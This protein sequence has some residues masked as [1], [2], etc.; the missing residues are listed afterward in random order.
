MGEVGRQ[1]CVVFD[2]DGVIVA[3][4][5]LWEQGW[6]AASR[7]RGMDWTPGDTRACQGKSVPEWADYVADRTGLTPEQARAEVVGYVTSAYD[8]GE[9]SLLP[10]AADLVRAA[11][12]RVPVGL[13][14]SAP[15]EVIDRVMARPELAGCF[16]ATVSS[17]EVPRGKPSPDVYLAAL[18][19]LD[20]DPERSFAIEDS[21]NGIRAAAAAGL[22]VFGL[23]HA[24]YPLAADAV[25]LAAGIFESLEEV[26]VRLSGDLDRAL[27][28]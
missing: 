17:A 5:H 19:R 9:V 22:R 13:A 4:E 12:S 3:S 15:R 11:S 20:G 14:T 7:G 1:V 21:S 27:A 8:R 23:E 2:L 25:C 6:R 24:Q 16:T 28:S 18:E 10:H 26:A